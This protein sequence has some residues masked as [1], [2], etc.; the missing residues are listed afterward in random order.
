M[1]F[2]FSKFPLFPGL[3]WFRLPGYAPKGPIFKV[4]TGLTFQGLTKPG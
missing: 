2:T 3:L 1:I 4:P